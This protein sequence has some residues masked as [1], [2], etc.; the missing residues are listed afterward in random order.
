VQ[1]RAS[2]TV[3]HRVIAAFGIW[4]ALMGGVGV[5][6][7]ALLSHLG[8][9]ESSS[10]LRVLAAV[11]TGLALIGCIAAIAF[12]LH[13]HRVVCGGLIRMSAGLE[14]VASTFDLSRRSASPRLDEFGRAAVAFDKLMDRIQETVSAVRSSTDS[15]STATREI[16]AGNGDISARTEEQAASLEETA[17]T[18]T[19]ITETV[20]QNADNAQRANELVSNATQIADTGNVVVQAMVSTIER[21]SLSSSRI[22]EITG[23]IEG[24]AFQTNILALNASVEAARAGENGRGFAVVAGEVRS[25]AQRCASAAKEIKSLIVSSVAT[26][27]EGSEQASKVSTAMID[28]KTAITQASQ[29][30]GEIAAASDEQ[31]RGIEQV[32]QAV[33]QMDRMTQANAALIEQAALAARLLEEQVTRLTTTVS[34]FKLADASEPMLVTGA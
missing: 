28:I 26:V 16:A 31:S 24:I 18:M 8:N 23:V 6:G 11:Q 3:R 30:V 10:L 19:Q 13:I 21:I 29:M 27:N 33:I 9:N 5:T 15:V 1:K 17:A 32:N 34:A 25:L 20:K 4:T 12:G 22:S 2:I 14:S 7:V